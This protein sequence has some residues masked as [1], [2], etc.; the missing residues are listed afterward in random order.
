MGSLFQRPAGFKHLLY[1]LT[2]DWQLFY[3]GLGSLALA[4]ST[5]CQAVAAPMLLVLDFSISQCVEGHSP[6]GTGP[7]HFSTPAKPRP[8]SVARRYVGIPI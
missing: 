6:C 3:L 4:I 1:G 7:E 5:A 2:L 8:R